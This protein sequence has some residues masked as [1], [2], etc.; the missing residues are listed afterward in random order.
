MT[1]YRCDACGNRTRFDVVERK[2]VKAF[3]HF[4]L[5]GNLTVESEE[6]LDHE[7]EGVTCR[8]CGATDAV[9][10]QTEAESGTQ[11]V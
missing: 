4:D 7:V 3:H 6:V 5:A 2:R 1:S 8:W 11:S 10:P 9:V